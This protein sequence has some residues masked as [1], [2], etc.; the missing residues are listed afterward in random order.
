MFKFP[1][2]EIE[3]IHFMGVGSTILHKNYEATHVKV[4]YPL[5]SPLQSN[6]ARD[7]VEIVKLNA[8]NNSPHCFEGGGGGGVGRTCS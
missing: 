6:V 7:G 2:Q 3:N 1:L 4:S 5:P 8:C